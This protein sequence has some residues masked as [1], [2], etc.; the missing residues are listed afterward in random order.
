MAKSTA[1]YTNGL[2]HEFF[3]DVWLLDFL[4]EP[5]EATRSVSAEVSITQTPSRQQTKQT[6]SPSLLALPRGPTVCVAFIPGYINDM[7]HSP[8]APFGATG[9]F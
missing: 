2:K 4:F 7:F 1:T 5:E 9:A 8:P 6:Y 3:S